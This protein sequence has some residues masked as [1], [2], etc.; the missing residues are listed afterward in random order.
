MAP[1]VCRIK[2]RAG[3]PLGLSIYESP[4]FFTLSREIRDNIYTCLLFTNEP[5]QVWRVSQHHLFAPDP[6]P[7]VSRGL[8]MGLLS[9]SKQIAREASAV[10]YSSNTFIFIGPD[11]WNPL[12]SFLLTIGSANRS[13]LR[14][15]EAGISP[16]TKI[17]IHPDG[18]LTS[19]ALGPPFWGRIVHPHDN[20]TR[21]YR[22][23]PN[24]WGEMEV[25]DLSP[26][27]EAVFRLLSHGRASLCLTLNIK[28]GYIPG[29]IMEYHG[30]ERTWGLELPDHVERMRQKF[31]TGRNGERSTE[32]RW[33]G[34]V[35][36]KLF[37]QYKGRLGEV[38]WDL[39]D[40]EPGPGPVYRGAVLYHDVIFTMRTKVEAIVSNNTKV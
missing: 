19:E 30:H 10:F 23:G 24:R 3:E 13:Y 11:T 9:T 15:V 17:T 25:D 1:M 8:T 6:N 38:G 14:K 18:T 35:R 34:R 22:K 5:I 4:T 28:A 39:L 12:C 21:S 27:V 16:P 33:K 29:F 26:A 36:E 31:A 7:L 40:T 32:V 37:G 20:Y 2:R